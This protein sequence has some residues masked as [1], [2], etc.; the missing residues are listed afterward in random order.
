[1]LSGIVSVV[2]GIMLLIQMPVS[3][4]WFI[5]FAIGVDLIVDGASLI[6]FATALH[7]LPYV[8]AQRAA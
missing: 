5:G 1:V 8:A 3:S 6:G 4:V 2:L 7:S